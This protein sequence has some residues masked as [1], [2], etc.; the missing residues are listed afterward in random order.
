ME[1]SKVA[2]VA[3]PDYEPARVKESLQ[4]GLEAIGGLESLIGKEENILLKPNLVRSAK[5]ERAVVTD[6]E[7][8]D[9]LITIL[10]ENGYENISC[11]DSCGLGTPEGIAKEAGLKE[12][13]EKHNVPLKD[14]LT[15]ERVKTADGKFLMIA[16][17]ALD[18]DALISVSKM[19]THALERITGAVKNQYGCISGVYKKLGHTQYPNAESFAHMLIELNQKVDP[20]LYICDG[21][22]AM[23]GNGPTSGDPVSMG[24]LLMSTDPIALDTVFCHLVNLDPSYVPTNLYGETLGLGTWHDDRRKARK[25]G[26]LDLLEILG[27]FQSRPYIIE[28]KCKKCGV[29]VESCPVEGKAVRFDNGRR[30]PPVYDYKKCIRCF[31]CQEMC[32]HQAIQVTKHRLPWGK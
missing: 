22:V 6:P 11:G 2:V 16:K 12:V 24:V 15:S 9:A 4:K 19:K 1:K 23:E 27:V 13:L 17:D 28:E 32:P 5:R 14:F 26:A 8:M 21:I 10:Q 7:V 18:C 20:R 3:C 25:K 31:C 29:C 30:N